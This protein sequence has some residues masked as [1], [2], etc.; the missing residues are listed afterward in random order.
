MQLRHHPAMSPPQMALMT[1]LGSI[2]VALTIACDR[3][4]RPGPRRG[5]LSLTHREVAI[6]TYFKR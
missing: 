4:H 6:G 2:L 3:A 5:G 1:A